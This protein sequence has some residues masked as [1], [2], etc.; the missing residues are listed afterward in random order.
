MLETAYLWHAYGHPTIGNKA[1]I[2]NVPIEKLAAFYQKYYQPDN[3]L[4]TVAGKFDSAKALAWIA[5]LFGKIPRPQ[6]TIEQPYTVEPE[7]D[8]ERSV[9]LR[10]V[11]DT[12]YVMAMY[13]MPAGSSRRCRHSGAVRCAGRRAF[14]PPLQG[15]GGQQE[16]RRRQYGFG[17][18]A[19]PWIHGRHAQLSPDQNLDEARQI[20]IKTVEDFAKEPPSKEEVDRVKT[21]IARSTSSWPWPTPRASH[22]MLTEYASQGD[23]RMLFLERDRLAAVTPEDVERVAKAYLKESN[24]TLGEFI[25]TKTPDRA[26]IPPTAPTDYGDVQELQGRRCGL[27]GRGLRSF[28]LQYREPP[29]PRQAFQRR[30]GGAA[31][32]EDSRRHGDCQFHRALRR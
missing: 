32:Q 7:Q 28:A 31:S 1:D 4:L 29:D 10:R 26:E 6:R 15:P 3:A 22:W 14:R 9:T 23:W 20:L 21:R 27:R 19:R 12:Q 24:R 2:E 16:G 17:R 13:H 5:E 25:P 8:G 11:G 18:V 30:E